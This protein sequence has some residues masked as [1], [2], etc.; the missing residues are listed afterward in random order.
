MEEGAREGVVKE[1]CVVGVDEELREGDAA[2]GGRGVDAGD[3]RGELCADGVGHEGEN[4]ALLGETVGDELLGEQGNGGE[5]S[6]D[7]QFYAR[8]LTRFVVE[9]DTRD[10]GQRWQRTIGDTPSPECSGERI[11]GLVLGET[12]R[13]I[14]V[15]TKKGRLPVLAGASIV[16]GANEQILREDGRELVAAGDAGTMEHLW[17]GAGIVGLG[18]ATSHDLLT[19]LACEDCRTEGAAGHAQYGITF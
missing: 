12:A 15:V 1:V 17:N 14:G 9:I 19:S 3:A 11:V 2:D 13:T 16:E 18:V 4:V 8:K 5:T 6:A 7:G 10:N